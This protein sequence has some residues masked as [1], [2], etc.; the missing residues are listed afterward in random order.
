MSVL[1]LTD[2][3]PEQL[4]TDL[5]V[6]LQHPLP[7]VKEGGYRGMDFSG[8]GAAPTRQK[9]GVILK[10]HLINHG[11]RGIVLIKLGLLVD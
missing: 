5:I 3:I 2:I 10:T 7:S 1:P 11:T 9:Q 8:D 6:D 4:P